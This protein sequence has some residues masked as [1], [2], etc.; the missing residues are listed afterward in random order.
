[1]AAKL[2]GDW[3]TAEQLRELLH[4]DPATG[5]FKRRWGSGGNG[6]HPD[7]T[8]EIVGT[9]AKAASKRRAC[10]VIALGSISPRRLANG[11]FRKRAYKAHQLAWLYTYGEWPDRE[12]DHI[13]GDGTDNRIANLRL[14]TTAQN[15]YNKGIRIDNK[16]GIKGVTW[17]ERSQKWLVH[18]GQGGKIHHVGLFSTIE[19]ARAAREAAA[20]QLH[21]KFARI[22]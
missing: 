8:G 20:R 21:G 4:Y 18:V 6:R 1:M 7:R 11:G 5:Q 16:S 15:G 19:E 10:A 3:P 13:N 14:A 12:I 9:V 22:D 17:S 2:L